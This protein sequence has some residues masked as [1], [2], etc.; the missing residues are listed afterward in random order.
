MPVSASGTVTT[1]PT[2]TQPAPTCKAGPTNS[3]SPHVFP[4]YHPRAAAV[5]SPALPGLGCLAA[6]VKAKSNNLVGFLW[7]LQAP[8]GRHEFIERR[9]F[10]GPAVHPRSL[11]DI[12]HLLVPLGEAGVLPS[13]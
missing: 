8:Q 9:S 6:R 5:D 7:A 11:V 12:A 10:T 4:L 1:S 13:A 2:C 3:S